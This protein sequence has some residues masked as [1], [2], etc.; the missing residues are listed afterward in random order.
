MRHNSA[1]PC[2]GKVGCKVCYGTVNV[3]FNKTQRSTGEWRI[4]ANP[5]AWG[6]PRAEIMVLGFSKGPR[7]KGEIDKINHNEIAYKGSRKQVGQILAYL[8]LLP[9]ASKD[10]LERDVGRL[11]ADENG[12]FHFG[13]LIRCAVER[14]DPKERKWKGSGGNMLGGFMESSFGREVAENCSKRFLTD[15]P[16]ETKLIIMLGLGTRGAYVREAR[17]LLEKARPGGWQK[18]NEVAYTDGK[19]MVAHVE[20]FGSQGALLPQWLGERRHARAA[21]GVAAKKAVATALAT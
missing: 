10:Q 11:I 6:N 1:L 15:L 16:A 21:L 3:E 5:L 18:F 8:G 2:H 13:S 9:Q 7:Q 17:S 14:Y 20:H 4:T 19:I 12:R